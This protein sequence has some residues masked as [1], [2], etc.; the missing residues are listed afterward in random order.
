MEIITL[1]EKNIAE[2]YICC[3]IADKK[4]KEGY[5]AKKDWIK[6][7][8][9]N[10]FIFKKLDVRGKVFIEYIPA[11]FAWA[12]I[13]A[14]D[15]MFINCFWVSGQYKGKGNGQRLYNECL[16]DSK[17][18]NG[19]VII[20]SKK[21]QPFLS[22]KKFF[23][24]QGFELCDTSEPFF[25]LWYKKLKE[26]APTPKFKDCA[27]NGECDIKEGIAVYYTNACPFTEYYVNTELIRITKEN[28]HK[29]KTVKIETLQ[30]AQSHF[31]P[32]TIYS[33]FNNGKFVTQQILSEKA[34]DKF[35]GLK[36]LK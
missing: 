5:E 29:I 11:E 28:G 14:P 6:N 24:R 19:I 32:F 16:N 25:E 12:P 18:K 31:I 20:S 9:D 34:F 23:Q 15:Y 10:G 1:N 3:A 35:I 2:E 33:I 8:F 26:N 27:K 30:Q 22:D 13:E 4:C 17:G 7:Q 21:K 36:S